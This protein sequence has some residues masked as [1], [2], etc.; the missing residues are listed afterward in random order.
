VLRSA[1]NSPPEQGDKTQLGP[2]TDVW[3]LGVILYE[4]L[5]Q[6]RPFTGKTAYAIRDQIRNHMPPHPRST[7]STLP[8]ALEWICLKALCKDP[9]K[10]YADGNALADDLQRHLDGDPVHAS[11]RSRRWPLGLA[12]AVVLL[13]L[14]IGVFA[15]TADPKPAA[16]EVSNTPRLTFESTPERVSDDTL[17][18]TGD[19]QASTVCVVHAPGLKPRRVRPGDS[20]TLRV[21]LEL[22]P[23][24]LEFRVEDR[25]GHP[26]PS[27]KVSVTRVPKWYEGSLPEERAPLPLPDGMRLGVKANEYMWERNGLT[28]TLIWVPAVTFQFGPNSDTRTATI[29]RGYWIGKHEVTWAQ[30]NAYAST[31]AKNSIGAQEHTD[32]VVETGLEEENVPLEEPIPA[33]DE[34][35][36]IRITWVDA[37]RFCAWLGLRL[38]TEAE[39]ELA[40][41]GPRKRRFPWGDHEL[42]SGGF[43]SRNADPFPYTAPPGS[44]PED[45]SP[46]GCM[47]M[48]GNVQEWVFDA[49]ADLP[50]GAL[51][52]YRGPSED[53]TERRV[54]RGG[55]WNHLYLRTFETT[56]R[57]K[58]LTH[59]VHREVGFRVCLT[60]P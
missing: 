40:A 60:G 44:F 7:D 26:S 35:S 39:W 11:R 31:G 15:G 54:V 57:F 42:K 16:E 56:Y 5:T 36:A 4:A 49:W 9:A 24:T 12:V 50:D 45:R 19:V 37:R 53:P 47:D 20:F 17:R 48:A 3:A 55:A 23:N 52:D 38:P 2:P 25:D 41:R 14:G 18:L 6:T 46:Y 21:P 10:R 58:R 34:S 33:P 28:F 59:Y 13:G 27:V 8:E 32:T 43:N 22:G 51:V 1:P 30:V 29:T